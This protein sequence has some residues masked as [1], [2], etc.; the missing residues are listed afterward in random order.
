[1]PSS[2]DKARKAARHSSSV[3][4]SALSRGLGVSLLTDAVAGVN[5]QPGDAQRA[6]REMV[7]A[8]AQ[9]TTTDQ[10]TVNGPDQGQGGNR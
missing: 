10:V 8:G 1:M 2:R 7:A 3:A 6:V 5:V 9:L 4:L